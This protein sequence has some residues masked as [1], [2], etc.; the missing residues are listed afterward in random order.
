MILFI[1]VI[2]TLVAIYKAMQNAKRLKDKNED[3]KRNKIRWIIRGMN[4]SE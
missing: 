3:I 4:K 1:C 2:I